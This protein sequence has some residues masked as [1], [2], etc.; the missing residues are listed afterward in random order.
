VGIDF[1]HP[2]AEPKPLPKLS[3]IQCSTCGRELP[4]FQPRKEHLSSERNE[5]V[6]I[7]YWNCPFCHELM[8][9]L[10]IMSGGTDARGLPYHKQR[11][12]LPIDGPSRPIPTTV[13][14][15]IAQEYREACAIL[16]PSPRASAAMSRR[17]LQSLLTLTGRATNH[18]LSKAIDELV[19]RAE[20]PAILSKEL[21]AVREI[22]NFGAH[23]RKSLATGEVLDVEPGEAE[24]NITV[25]E[26]LFD[27][28]YRELPERQARRDALND[29]LRATGHRPLDAE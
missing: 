3:G 28:Y 11:T 20:L 27:F 23:P 9:T 22:G 5:F 4:P 1:G 26:H 2:R 18:D 7:E 25:L 17:C 24:W 16:E 8:G 15:V 29:K 21:D 14:A 19:E 6:I 13:P 12:I 10:N